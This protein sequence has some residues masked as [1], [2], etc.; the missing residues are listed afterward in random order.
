MKVEYKEY[1]IEIL[2]IKNYSTKSTDNIFFYDFEYNKGKVIEERTHTNSKHGIRIKNKLSQSIIS[3]AII[4]EYGGATT[5]HEKSFFI[6]NQKMWICACNKIYCLEIPTLEI[7]W[8]GK[9]DFATN[10]SINPYKNDFIIHGEL[11][12]IRISRRGEIKWK[13]GARDIF[14]TERAKENFKINGDIIE[15]EDWEGYTYKIDESGNE[16]KKED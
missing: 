15:V 6:D 2:D 5:I 4:C 12:I 1:E 7:K 13:F 3:S 10:F 9:F 14:V 11:E 8:Y 16:I